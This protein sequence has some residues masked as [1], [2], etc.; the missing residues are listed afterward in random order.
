[1]GTV[2]MMVL[3]C[4]GKPI[5]EDTLHR[6]SSSHGTHHGD[7][8]HAGLCIFIEGMADSL[9]H[10][11]FVLDVAQGWCMWL[12][13]CAVQLATTS[14]G[15]YRQRSDARTVAFTITRPAEGKRN[16]YTSL[17]EPCW[18]VIDQFVPQVRA[19]ND[20]HATCCNTATLQPR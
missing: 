15:G 2:C 10:F 12:H 19:P 3:D 18:S 16:L 9:E 1:M 20:T 7:L 8:D 5:H 14:T 6:T 13:D 17:T 4:E 11:E